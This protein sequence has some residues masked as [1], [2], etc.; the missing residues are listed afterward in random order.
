[1]QFLL[2]AGYACIIPFPFRSFNRGFPESFFVFPLLRR[3]RVW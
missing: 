1:M 2:Q 3:Q